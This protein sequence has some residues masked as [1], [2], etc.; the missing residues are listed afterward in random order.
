MRWARTA[1]P[2]GLATRQTGRPRPAPAAD[3]DDVTLVTHGRSLGD[4]GHGRSDLERHVHGRAVQS[5][6]QTHRPLQRVPGILVHQAPPLLSLDA[7]AAVRHDG[8][9]DGQHQA[10][11]RAR[12]RAQLCGLPQQAVAL[13]E[14]QVAQQDVASRLHGGAQNPTQI[15]LAL[16]GASSPPHGVP[17]GTV[18]ARVG[19]SRRPTSARLPT[20]TRSNEPAVVRLMVSRPAISS[21]GDSLGRGFSVSRACDARRAG[22]RRGS[23]RPRGPL[24]PPASVGSRRGRTRGRRR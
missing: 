10:E 14:A 18:G 22:G 19:R 13:R 1:N 24:R 3:R 16:Y 7:A 12:P 23:S 6:K 17:P 9:D 15:C 20:M 21:L 5:L 2:L 4:R 8:V 11:L